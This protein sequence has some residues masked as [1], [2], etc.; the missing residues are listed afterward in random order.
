MGVSEMVYLG[1]AKE[2]ILDEIESCRVL[3]AN[4]HRKEHYGPSE[5]DR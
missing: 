2:T 1:F 5:E 4:C 3:C